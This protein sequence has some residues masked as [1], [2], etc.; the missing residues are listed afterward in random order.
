MGC[1]DEEEE[2]ESLCVGRASTGVEGLSSVSAEFPD[3]SSGDVLG[4]FDADPGSLFAVPCELDPGLEAGNSVVSLL[5]A[6]ALV[7]LA[8][9]VVSS[10]ISTSVFGFGPSALALTFFS[11][12]SFDTTP[13]FASGFEEPLDVPLW[14]LPLDAVVPAAAEGATTVFR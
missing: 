13:R 14:V 7:T 11:L 10:F 6:A 12:T 3:P 2:T 9:F 1:K 8:A 5:F 4:V